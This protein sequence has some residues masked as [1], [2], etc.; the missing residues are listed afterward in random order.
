[1]MLNHPTFMM[2]IHVKDFKKLK[3]I[4]EDMDNYEIYSWYLGTDVVRAEVQMYEHDGGVTIENMPGRW[5]L[6]VRAYGRRPD[7]FYDIALW[8]LRNTPLFRRLLSEG[9]V[10]IREDTEEQLVSA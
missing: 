10:E 8:K 5:W 2:R 6:Y 3:E 7:L 1:M 4:L 9:A